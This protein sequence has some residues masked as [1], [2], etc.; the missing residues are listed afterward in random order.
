MVCYDTYNWTVNLTGLIDDSIW[1]EFKIRVVDKFNNELTWENV[2]FI[3]NNEIESI[4]FKTGVPS[5]YL[6]T[7]VST[8][9]YNPNYVLYPLNATYANAI[10]YGDDEHRESIL[11]HEQGVDGTIDDSGYWIAEYP[12][13][14]YQVRYCL[15]FAGG[16]WDEPIA[17]ENDLTLDNVYIHWWTQGG[18]TGQWDRQAIH[19]GRMT[20][21]YDFSWLI[22]NNEE[23]YNYSKISTNAST[24]DKIVI[25]VPGDDGA[26]PSGITNTARLYCQ[27]INITSTIPDSNFDGDSIY[28]F[29]IGLNH[30]SS[31]PYG[32]AGAKIFS[33]YSFPSFLI[34]NVPDDIFTG[35]DNT[36]DT[37]GDTIPDYWEMNGTFTHPFEE[38]TDKDGYNDNV[39][40]SPNVYW[41]YTDRTPQIVSVYPADES[42]SKQQPDFRVTMFDEDTDTLSAEWWWKDESGDWYLFGTNTSIDSTGILTQST[43]YMSDTNFT[44]D[45]HVYTWSINISDGTHW[46]N[47]SYTF[48]ADVDEVIQNDGI[49][50]FVWLK[51]G[52]AWDIT[53]SISGFNEASEYIAIWNKDTWHSTDWLWNKYY[54]DASGTNFTVS[55]YN[56]VKI[57]L[58]DSGTQTIYIDVDY[59]DDYTG[60]VNQTL[61]DNSS[62]GKGY[63]FN[64]SVKVGFSSTLNTL[65]S[66]I[67]LTW[68]WVSGWAEAVGVWNDTDD[69]NPKW[70]W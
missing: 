45:L 56:V 51:D 8:D 24:R 62:E 69:D 34:F 55:K 60:D 23:G 36:T 59:A 38:D 40:G 47:H 53:Q 1:H 3:M 6:D 9:L 63:N 11:R 44:T 48:R 66:T 30:T 13:D 17:I 35:V 26:D 68:D 54:G 67:G 18:Y 64:A 49:D 19:W 27:H 70:D 20:T 21:L 4:F 41:Y 43:I 61:N 57:Y 42:S 46:T 14:T 25:D 33:N 15:K 52:S 10:F 29:F 7:N 12:T 65:N 28:N 58:T 2:R 39:D 16:W 32:K 37:D 50:Y 5:T 22:A 31:I